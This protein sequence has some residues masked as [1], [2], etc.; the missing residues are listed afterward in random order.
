M[1]AQTLSR[2]LE[3]LEEFKRPAFAGEARLISVLEQ[4]DKRRFTD[5]DQLIGFHETLLFMRAYPRTPRHLKKVEAML[6]TFQQRVQL[7]QSIEAN[8]EPF[9]ASE[10]SGI[11][12]TALIAVFSYHVTRWL[13]NRHSSEVRIDW[14]GYEDG[15]RLGQTLPRFVP[16]LEEESLVEANIPYT[17][18]LRAAL[19]PHKRELSWLIRRFESLPLSDTEKAELYDSLK[20]YLHWQPRDFRLTRTGMKRKV[21]EVFY[22]AAPLLTRRDV[23]LAEELNAPPLPVKK[24]SR[25]EGA[26]ML[27][28]IRDTS[29]IRYRELHGFTFGDASRVVRV[30]AGRGVE[31]FVNGIGAE[32]RLPLRAY[33]S[34][35]ILKNGVPIGYTEGISLFERI[36][37]GIN[38]YYTFR[39]GESA[40]LY[41]RV[42]RMFRQL[43]GVT[44]FSIDP[45]QIGFENEEGIESGAFWFY[46]KMGFRPV[47]P[48]IAKLAGEEERKIATR[49]AYRT[50]AKTLRRMALGHMLFELEPSARKVWDGFHIRNLGL[51]VGRRLAERFDGDAAKMRRVAVSATGR[52][53]GVKPAAWKKAEQQAFE[54][55]ALLLSLIPNLSRWTKDEKDAVVNIVRAKAGAEES[56]YLKLLQQHRKLK[57][58]IVR[59]GS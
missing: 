49:T 5:A 47:R 40:W 32:H 12:G 35:L 24:L 2:L 55:L 43:L 25:Q 53:L 44:T 34:A 28:M 21:R 29:T 26:R 1:P 10:A 58:E 33:H 16:L 56:R 39:E 3:L 59:L 27:D 19:G 15:A 22:H 8:L 50:S 9:S 20:L 46:R 6:Q 4:L 54:N 17:A 14:E 52:A 18:W 11:A 36:E 57:D 7:L 51:A 45:Y 42:M 31:F 23:S 38:I 30:D 48:Q 41:A 13:V 37:T